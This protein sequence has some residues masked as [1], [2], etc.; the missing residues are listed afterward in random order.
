[1]CCIDY[2]FIFICC[3]LPYG[4]IKFITKF[5]IQISRRLIK[6]VHLRIIALRKCELQQYLLP[7][8]KIRGIHN[9]LFTFRNSKRYALKIDKTILLKKSLVFFLIKSVVISAVI[10]SYR[11]S[12]YI[13]P[14]RQFTKYISYFLLVRLLIRLQTHTVYHNLGVRRIRLFQ[15]HKSIQKC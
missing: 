6:K 10:F 11:D 2:A 14:K 7:L 9:I 1:M 12:R 13:F 4:F 5:N 8:R 3:R 15:P